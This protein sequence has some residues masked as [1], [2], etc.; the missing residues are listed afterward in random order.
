MMRLKIRLNLLE[1]QLSATTWAGFTRVRLWAERCGWT[2]RETLA[3]ARASLLTSAPELREAFYASMRKAR[4]A[5]RLSEIKRRALAA[6]RWAI[7]HDTV[8]VTGV[9]NRREKM[10]KR[11]QL[12][13]ARQQEKL[14]R[15]LERDRIREKKNQKIRQTYSVYF[16]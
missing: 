8:P 6:R 4:E 7:E 1:A 10:M 9:A 16:E 13:Q 2:I 3:A 11:R 15:K 14:V 12:L 5:F